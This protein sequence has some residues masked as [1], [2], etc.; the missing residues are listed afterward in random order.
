MTNKSNIV[1]LNQSHWEKKSTL[2][3]KKFSI[4]SLNN[5]GHNHAFQVVNKHRK[6][7]SRSRQSSE[8]EL[9][10]QPWLKLRIG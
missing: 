3:V 5:R 2:S 7:G 8:Q 4:A 9:I 6:T 1:P 10:G